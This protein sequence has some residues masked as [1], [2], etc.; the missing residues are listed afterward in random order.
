METAGNNLS[1]ERVRA[2]V[3]A[4]GL[5]KQLAI[6]IGM[7]D[8]NLTKYLDGQLTTFCRLLDV[9]GLEVVAKGHVNDLRKVLKEVL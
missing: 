4:Y 9:L 7:S 1:A 5:Q 6:E 3:K 2:A 8:G